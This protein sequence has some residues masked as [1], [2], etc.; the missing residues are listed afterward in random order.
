LYT[1]QFYAIFSTL[2]PC[3][4]LFCCPYISLDF[5]C[6]I[7]GTSLSEGRRSKSLVVWQP[8]GLVHSWCSL[9]H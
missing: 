7:V 4:L 1:E 6:F 3:F 8:S 2:F 9:H 5:N